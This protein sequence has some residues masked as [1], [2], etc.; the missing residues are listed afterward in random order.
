MNESETLRPQRNVT[1]K[2]KK[3][4]VLIEI[5][6]SWKCTYVKFE[7]VIFGSQWDLD[8]S[9]DVLRPFLPLLLLRLRRP[10]CFSWVNH[11]RAVTTCRPTFLRGN[12][13]SVPDSAAHHPALNKERNLVSSVTKITDYSIKHFIVMGEKVLCVIHWQMKRPW[14]L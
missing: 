13:L 7:E 10:T 3:K 14:W 2:T 1:L 8:F 9:G 12:I 6:F 5:R 11:R 4:R